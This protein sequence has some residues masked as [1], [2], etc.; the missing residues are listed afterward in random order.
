[1]KL[2]RLVSSSN[3]GIFENDFNESIDIKE[4]AEI[5]LQDASVQLDAQE[6]HVDHSN[7][8]VKFQYNVNQSGATQNFDIPSASYTKSNYLDLH[9]A[10]QDGL[11]RSMGYNVKQIGHQFFVDN[12]KGGT[13]IGSRFCPNTAQILIT[14]T[15]P[16]YGDHLNGVTISSTGIISNTDTSDATDN[17]LMYSN[18]E[19]C[20]GSMV[21]RTR[22]RT[23]SDVDGAADN[24]H[25][26]DFGVSDVSPKL[27]AKDSTPINLTDSQ[28]TFNIK[29]QKKG[30]NYFFNDKNTTNQ[31]AG[32][33]PLT[34]VAS[35][36]RTNNDVLEIAMFSGIIRG[37]IYRND[38]T[39]PII[40]LFSKSME[41]LY[42]GVGANQK[43]YPY[44][45]LH[46]AAANCTLDTYSRFFFDPVNSNITFPQSS[47]GEAQE[48]ENGNLTALPSPP[49]DAKPKTRH[50]SRV[51]FESPVL[52]HYLGFNN[53]VLNSQDPTRITFAYD[54]ENLFKAGLQFENIIVETMNLQID[55]Y[56]GLQKGRRNILGSVPTIENSNGVIV[57]EANNQ[58]F[59]DIKNNQPRSLRNIKVRVL[60]SDLTDC[61]TVGL[62]SITLIIRD[63]S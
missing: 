26:F 2:I 56:D 53:N 36:S 32:T 15:A 50:D 58:N 1:M 25:G 20:K 10:I 61:P 39:T 18:Q 19:L 17:N 62:N 16:P 22:L 52:A 7:D 48:E 12:K 35:P 3:D 33:A 29:V 41:A 38:A 28:K 6:F 43:L 45:V 46:G 23:L 21:V 37:R 63:K 57:Y 11:N 49:S 31:D 54:S 51:T 4:N 30:T 44:I 59:L 40:E 47:I 13:R 60:F 5:C 55:S 14:N 42:P 8:N 27:W 34:Y 24:L 9:N